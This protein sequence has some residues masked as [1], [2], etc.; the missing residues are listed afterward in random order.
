MAPKR[1]GMS[2]FDDELKALINAT[3]KIFPISQEMIDT[4]LNPDGYEYGRI[5]RTIY[6]WSGITWEYLIADDIDIRW[7]DISEKPT[8]FPPS[9]HVHDDAV[10]HIADTIKHIT[11]EERA[12]WDTVSNKAALT[13]T[14]PY[15]ST[16]HIHDDRYY[17]ESEVDALLVTR[18]PALHV[19]DDRYYTESEMDGKLALKADGT[20]PSGH[21]S[22]ST[23]HVTQT[24][25]DTWHAKTKI[26]ISAVQ[27][28]DN[29]IWYE[30]V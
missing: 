24:D 19:H 22:N 28:T 20:T 21:T 25:K 5:E 2:L 12:L 14:H 29:S 11:A 23:V 13:H 1:I 15:A 7:T 4:N 17:T 30:E 9:V 26:I 3:A 27:P 8:T 16:V 10:A 18:A 6:R